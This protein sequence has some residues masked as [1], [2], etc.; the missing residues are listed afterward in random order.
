MTYHV[1][2]ITEYELNISSH[3]RPGFDQIAL[4]GSFG[5]AWLF[6]VPPTTA[7]IPA[8]SM[9]A[10]SPPT[11]SCFFDDYT[12]P[13]VVDMLRNEKP[14]FFWFED[15]KLTVTLSTVREPVGESE[16]GP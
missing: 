6:F 15:V 13:R 2:N 16:P 8:N 7:T 11:F 14:L 9:W 1:G 10:G 4:H 5:D 12:W 3:R